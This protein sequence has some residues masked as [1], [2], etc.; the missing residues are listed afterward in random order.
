M[1]QFANLI[2]QYS[3]QIVIQKQLSA[4]TSQLTQ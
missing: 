2:W 1:E 3:Q 4:I